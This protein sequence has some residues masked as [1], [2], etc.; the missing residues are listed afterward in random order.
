MEWDHTDSSSAVAVGVP[1]SWNLSGYGMGNICNAA[2]DGDLFPAIY[3]VGR[4]RIP[5]EGCLYSVSLFSEV[6]DLWKAGADDD[7]GDRL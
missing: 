4:C 1:D 6:P 5:A 3:P 2:A 7:D